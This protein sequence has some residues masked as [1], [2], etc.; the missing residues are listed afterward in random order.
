[1]EFERMLNREC[2]PTPDEMVRTI[3]KA[4]AL[5]VALR[6]FVEASYDIAPEVIFGG[7]KYGWQ[8]HYRKG[9]R[10]LCDLYPERDT[11][12]VLVVLGRQECEQ[13]LARIHEFSP[14]VRAVFEMTP[15]LHDGRWLWIRP[16]SVDDIASLATLL[17][18]KRKPKKQ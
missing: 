4:G 17:T 3:G 18:I 12:T 5:W 6:A 2:P 15:P 13:A 9:G 16:S 11:F 1:M 10:T 8:L 7:R 14:N